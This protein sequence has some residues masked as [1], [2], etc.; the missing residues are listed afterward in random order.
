VLSPGQNQ[1]PPQQQAESSAHT[2]AIA[3]ASPTTSTTSTPQP[4]VITTTAP[5]TH[6]VDSPLAATTIHHSRSTHRMPSKMLLSKSM[7]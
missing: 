6:G 3:L 1:P 4:I 7:L 2:L 5:E